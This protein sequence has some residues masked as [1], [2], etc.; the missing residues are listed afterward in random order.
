MI[1]CLPDHFGLRPR[2]NGGKCAFPAVSVFVGEHRVQFTVAQRGLVNAHV[3]ADVLWKDQPFAGVRTLLPVE[4]S[5]QIVTVLTLQQ[6]PVY[7]VVSLK[8]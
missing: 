2:H 4:V 6:M 7:I 1:Q 5:A 8:R 3:G